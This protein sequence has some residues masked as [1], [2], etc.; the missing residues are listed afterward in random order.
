MPAM[1]SGLDANVT[2]R[3]FADMDLI[4]VDGGVVPLDAGLRRWS[5]IV[6]AVAGLIVIGGLVLLARHRAS[7]PTTEDPMAT[8]LPAR[9]TPPWSH[10]RARTSGT[11]IW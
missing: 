3:T 8:W 10:C 1:V 5:W 2:N 7:G 11:C 4:E 6:I 9:D